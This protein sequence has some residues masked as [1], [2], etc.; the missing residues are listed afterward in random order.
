MKTIDQRKVKDFWDARADKYGS[1]DFNSIANLE[2]D[3]KNLALKVELETQKVFG[4]L[5]DIQGKRILDLGAGVGQ[6]AFRFI[7]RQAKSVKAVE[8]SEA[9][10]KIGRKEVERR[11][12]DNIEFVA[13][14]AERF[15]TDETFDLI[16]IS[17]LFVYMN[18]DQADLLV[19]NLSRFCH[20]ETII[21]LRDGTSILSERHV[22][23]SKHSEHLKSD[24]SA[25]YRTATEYQ[26]LFEGE[27]FSLLHHENMFD[28][29]C[30]LNKYPE[31]RLRVYQFSSNSLKK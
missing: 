1:L 21:F 10:V 26:E 31:T 15:Q 27:G 17:G 20:P 19:S 16:Y 23:N 28:E 6:W 24:Y 18:E 11:G 3:P 13:S 8:Y 25:M 30:P 7:D 5:G 2:E 9:L 12:L 29:G 4:L 22:I 14:P